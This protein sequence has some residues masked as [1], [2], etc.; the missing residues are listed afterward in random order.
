MSLSALVRLGP[1]VT[2]EAIRNP[3]SV[4]EGA[5][6]YQSGALQ[7]QRGARV[8]VNHDRD[9]P[10][11]TVVELVEMADGEGEWL[12]ARCSITAAPEW[13]RKGTAASI[14]YASTSRQQVAGWERIL[15]GLV[16]EIS[17]LSPS[18][19]PAQPMARVVLLR[20]APEPVP[21]DHDLIP[22]A[23]EIHP[24]T[25]PR[26]TSTNRGAEGNVTNGHVLDHQI[27]AAQWAAQ[28]KPGM[29]RRPNIGEVTAVY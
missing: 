9:R 15:K 23:R 28:T 12:T 22:R 13:L 20:E 2:L 18:V 17:I 29:I 3:A 8:F 27:A 14:A 11:G 26:A 7:L 6:L 24:T 4:R 19:K 5:E 10:V 16:T 25:Q 1:L 21:C